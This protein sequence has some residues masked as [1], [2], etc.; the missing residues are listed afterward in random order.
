MI[1]LIGFMGAG[2][3]TIGAL[4]ATAI[5]RPFIDLDRLVEN[6]AGCTIAQIFSR[7]GEADFRRREFEALQ[8]L[9]AGWNGVLAVGGGAPMHPEAQLVLN[10]ATVI[11]LQTSL[12]HV[13]ARLGNDPSR[14]MLRNK[15]LEELFNARSV[16]YGALADITIWVED[17]TPDQIVTNLKSLLANLKPTD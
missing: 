2:K 15:N 5:D 11:Y 4:L 7:W 1:V 12:D 6:S 13:I 14:P 10:S 9:P 16:I 8:H 17:I 3:T